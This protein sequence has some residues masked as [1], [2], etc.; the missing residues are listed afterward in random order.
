MEKTQTKSKNRKDRI[1]SEIQNLKGEIW[2]DIKNYE[3][4][5]KVS[6]FGRVRG[7]RNIIHHKIRRNT[8]VI[9]RLIDEF[10]SEK[11]FSLKD[12]VAREFVE[13]PFN[14]TLVYHIDGNFK[15]NNSTNL[16][17]NNKTSRKKNIDKE[18]KHRILSVEN[19]LSNET[20]IERM[21]EKY[22]KDTLDFSKTDYSYMRR[23]TTVR[24]IKHDIEITMWPQFML[25]KKH[26][27]DECL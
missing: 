20:F 18:K 14:Y 15:N 26:F 21:V 5:Y 22:G 1:W 9:V 16:I 27:C 23:E 24:C 3:G 2:K 11:T 17:W 10:N 6:N 8:T 4:L 7:K 19:K 13:N 25:R 12:I